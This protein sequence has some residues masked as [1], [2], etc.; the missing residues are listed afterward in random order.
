MHNTTVITIYVHKFPNCD[1][2]STMRYN[3]RYKQLLKIIKI[4]DH[5][6]RYVFPV[7]HTVLYGST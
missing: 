4:N 7:A 3:I 2:H 5:G 1:H 6:S